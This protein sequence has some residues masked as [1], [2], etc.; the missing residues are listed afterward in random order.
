MIN[1]IVN[2]KKNSNRKVNELFRLILVRSSF[3]GSNGLNLKSSLVTN[4][5]FDISINVH[6]IFVIYQRIPNISVL[7]WNIGIYW[8]IYN[9]SRN[10]LELLADLIKSKLAL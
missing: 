7:Y 5:E 2:K 6:H 4:W 9:I 8:N 3:C 1:N 10:F